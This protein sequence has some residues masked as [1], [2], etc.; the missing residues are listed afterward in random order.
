MDLFRNAPIN[1]LLSEITSDFEIKVHFKMG[2]IGNR[3]SIPQH[4]T[5]FY[6]TSA[7][8]LHDQKVAEDMN[9]VG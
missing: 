1:Q 5:I 2:W 9:A 6:Q 4:T 8:S 7:L 3:I